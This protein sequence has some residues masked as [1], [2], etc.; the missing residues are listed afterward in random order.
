MI[1]ILSVAVFLTLPLFSACTLLRD[2][3]VEPVVADTPV[4]PPSPS[5]SNGPSEQAKVEPSEQAKVPAKE[6]PTAKPKL[7]QTGKASWYG[8][9]FDG[10][11]TAS[12][13]VFD[14]AELTAAHAN[15]P[16]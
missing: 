3:A 7:P 13:D 10:K 8:P 5:R 9:K 1:R 6:K 4:T 11:L 16:F 14:K 15:L 2:K 12:G